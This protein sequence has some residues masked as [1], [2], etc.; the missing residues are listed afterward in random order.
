VFK[1]CSAGEDDDD[2]DDD[3]D[4]DDDDLDTGM[5]DDDDN[6]DNCKDNGDDVE[7]IIDGINDVNLNLEAGGG[8][9]QRDSFGEFIPDI[10]WREK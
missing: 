1:G 7:A 2:D 9:Q 10:F 8:V 6:D 5:P 3:D 4:N